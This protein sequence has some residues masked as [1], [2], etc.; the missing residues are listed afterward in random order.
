M[1]SDEVHND[2]AM[3]AQKEAKEA[4]EK[5]YEK[6][7]EFCPTLIDKCHLSA[8]ITIGAL[9]SFFAVCATGQRYELDLLEYMLNVMNDK[10]DIKITKTPRKSWEKETTE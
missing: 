1:I 4:I 2:L 5:I 3:Q 10:H 8:N 6:Y 9:F 7:E